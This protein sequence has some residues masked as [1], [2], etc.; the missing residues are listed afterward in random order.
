M[1]ATSN[2]VDTSPVIRGVW[3]LESILGAPPPPPPLDV[4]ALSPDLRGTKNIRD[5]L[6]AHRMSE[7][8]FGCHQKIAPMGFAFENFNPIGQWR[9]NSPIG[10]KKIDPS[11]ELSNGETLADI[12][13]LKKYLLSKEILFTRNLSEKLISHATGRMIEPTDRSEVE[14]MLKQL[15]EKRGGLRDVVHR[16]VQSKTFQTK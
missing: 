2:G 1:T 11:A 4:P 6:E 7:A 13:A 3:V 9:D 14:R 5:Q 15:H 8:C 10:N 12:S 16:V